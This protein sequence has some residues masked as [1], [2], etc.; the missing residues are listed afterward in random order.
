MKYLVIK[1][2]ELSDQYECDAFRKPLC[3]TD[4]I[5]KWE[6]KFGYEI[7]RICENGKLRLIKE[8]DDYGRKLPKSIKEV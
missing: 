6:A 7:Y 2:E 8:Y 3:V 1:C 5:S 4:D